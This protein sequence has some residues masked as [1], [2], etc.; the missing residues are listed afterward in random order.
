MKHALAFAL[1]ALPLT[2]AAQFD[3]LQQSR[4]A[5]AGPAFTAQGLRFGDKPTPAFMAA[6]GLDADDMK[7]PEV[8][9]RHVLEVPGGEVVQRLGFVYGRLQIVLLSFEPALF[10]DVVAVYSRRLGRPQARKT[11]AVSNALGASFDNEVALW[12]TDSGLLSI[13]KY[14]SHLDAGFGSI[15]SPS[16]LQTQ[17]QQRKTGREAAAGRF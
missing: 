16:Y 2:A 7:K 14:G 13:R 9:S 3:P 17:K 4:P 6:T 15:F 8:Y 11:E 5:P 12:Q 1:L 10:D